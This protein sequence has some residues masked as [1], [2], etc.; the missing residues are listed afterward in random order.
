MK[1]KDYPHVPVPLWAYDWINQ[2]KPS[3]FV[4]LMHILRETIGWHDPATGHRKEE[5]RA[6]KLEIAAATGLSPDTVVT[7]LKTLY[8][9]E[10]ID[11]TIYKMKAQGIRIQFPKL[12][13]ES[14]IPTQPPKN[15]SE[16][17]E[18]PTLIKE[19]SDSDKPG[20][21]HSKAASDPFK[22][23]FKETMFKE[24]PPNPLV[25]ERLISLGA[26][27]EAAQSIAIQASRLNKSENYLDN[28]ITWA[29]ELGTKLKSPIA[30]IRS[31]IKKGEVRLPSDEFARQQAQTDQ[32]RRQQSWLKYA[33]PPAS[34][35][36]ADDYPEAGAEY[37][38]AGGDLLTEPDQVVQPP[39]QPVE[40]LPEMADPDAPAQGDPWPSEEEA[41]Q[42]DQQAQADMEYQPDP[43]LDMPNPDNRI[44]SWTERQNIIDKLKAAGYR[45]PKYAIANAAIVENYLLIEF[46]NFEPPAAQYLMGLL[47]PDYPTI[48]G[49]EARQV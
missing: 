23:R 17:S 28:L 34:R 18:I 30:V 48:A 24:T 1:A 41:A 26:T 7:G 21:A 10:L 39:A 8:E 35:V 19:N 36:F 45:I 11:R 15:P 12:I 13:T 42:L 22:E 2:L 3:E 4:L 46:T 16:G 14:E 43:P 5:M 25:V 49:V 20:L 47:K 38:P 6:T 31:L 37:L 29:E 9:K 44:L 40:E 32:D 27:P 33:A